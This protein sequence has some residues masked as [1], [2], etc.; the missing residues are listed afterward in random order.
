M[1]SNTCQISLHLFKQDQ[2]IFLHSLLLSY[3]YFPLTLL[4]T[5]SLSEAGK[6]RTVS[7]QH[8]TPLCESISS[9][10][11]VFEVEDPEIFSGW[12][13]GLAASVS[14][15]I[16]EAGRLH[17]CILW[18]HDRKWHLP[19]YS[20]F[21]WFKFTRSGR[22]EQKNSCWDPGRQKLLLQRAG[23]TTLDLICTFLIRVNLSP[24][25][26]R[27]HHYWHQDITGSRSGEPLCVALFLCFYI[28][29]S[30]SPFIFFYSF[31]LCSNSCL[32]LYDL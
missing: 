3:S 32:I 28:C 5:V 10:L 21:C 15:L 14:S 18:R 17:H 25:S 8:E 22:K 1:V 26:W 11:F 19:A 13:T 12:G 27:T 6:E 23:S 30:V 2:Q 20:Y 7:N 24:E 31:I 9:E 4:S 29:M 16:Q